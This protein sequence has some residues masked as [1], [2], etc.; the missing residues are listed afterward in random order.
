[1]KKIIKILHVFLLAVILS[2]IVFSPVQAEAVIPLSGPKGSGSF[3]S[4]IAV[5]PN[6]NLL[7][8]GPTYS[9]V[10]VSDIGAVYMYDSY[11]TL[12]NTFTGSHAGDE[13]GSGGFHVLSDGNFLVMSPLWA[14][15]STTQAGAITWCP[16]TTSC[17]GV[18][19]LSKSL[20]GTH[21]GEQLTQGWINQLT[22]GNY[23]LDFPDWTN[24][25]ATKAGAVMWCSETSGCKG[26]ISASNSL[27]GTQSNDQV[28]FSWYGYVGGGGGESM[29]IPLPGGAYLVSSMY[30][31]NGSQTVAGEVTWCAGGSGSCVGTIS[32]TNS[33]VG[34]HTNDSIGNRQIYILPNGSAV[35]DSRDWDNSFGAV[36]WCGNQ[37]GCKGEVSASNSLVGSHANDRIGYIDSYFA[38]DW[39]VVLGYYWQ[40]TSTGQQ[41]SV[42]LCSEATGLPTGYINFRNS[43]LGPFSNY[44]F[45]PVNQEMIVSFPNENMVKIFGFDFPIIYLPLVIH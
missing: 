38:T 23:V 30:W 42:T 40:D 20:A 2:V 41:G 35:I 36:T 29:I 4:S 11:L 17:S 25:T 15:G 10:T 3:S 16:E 6:G 19:S 9:S 13:V 21:A 44:Y 18:V 12:I 39:Y 37:A 14:N 32:A 1:M 8:A 24:G 5:L 45:N 26:T 22:D 28:G 34:T 31:A 33:L 43:V 7:V 27:V